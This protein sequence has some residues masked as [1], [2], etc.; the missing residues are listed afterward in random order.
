MKCPSSKT[1]LT[2]SK[3]VL[4]LKKCFLLKKDLSLKKRKAKFSE[5]FFGVFVCFLNQPS[6]DSFLMLYAHLHSLASVLWVM[7]WADR[8][9]SR[10]AFHW[11]T[12][13]TDSPKSQRNFGW[14][15]YIKKQSLISLISCKDLEVVSLLSHEKFKIQFTLLSTFLSA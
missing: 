4:A 5:V 8:S 2:P 13:R 15:I 14:L 10:I 12:D 3:E 9:S 6:T 1:V 11:S 7:S